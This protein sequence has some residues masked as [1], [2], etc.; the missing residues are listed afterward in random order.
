[1]SAVGEQRFGDFI[2]RLFA[3]RESSALELIPDVMPVAPVLDSSDPIA[4]AAR[5]EREASGYIAVAGTAAQWN[6][7]ALLN[8][9]GSGVIVVAGVRW[10][11]TLNGMQAGLAEEAT[12][13][14]L[15]N[16]IGNKGWKDS[17]LLLTTSPVAQLKQG[18]TGGISIGASS[19]S[20]TLA[21]DGT[22]FLERVILTPGRALVLD[23]LGVNEAAKAIFTWTERLAAPDDLR[24]PAA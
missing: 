7:L 16:L 1:M 17:R 15:G 14:A 2:R 18:T 4:L 8:P 24:P 5:R 6:H 22:G 10:V 12:I 20:T 9:A 3:L 21:S 23:S 13:A 11:G 19:L